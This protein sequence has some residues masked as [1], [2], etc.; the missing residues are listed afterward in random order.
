[1]GIGLGIVL[2]LIGLVLVLDIINYNIPHVDDEKLGWVL[3]IV[4]V[5]ALVVSLVFWNINSR[6]RVSVTR[7][8]EI[9]R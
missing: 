7:D 5:L 4:G 2:I 1:M 8:D 6:R 9:V 3:L